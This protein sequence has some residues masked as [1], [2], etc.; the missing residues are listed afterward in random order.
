LRRK[1]KRRRRGGGGIGREKGQDRRGIGPQT[2]VLKVEAD[3]FGLEG[4][5]V[6]DTI[7]GGDPK[8]GRLDRLVR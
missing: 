8:A 4:L 2:W 3:D 6:R 1:R 5:A 7:N